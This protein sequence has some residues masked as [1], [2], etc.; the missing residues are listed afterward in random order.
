MFNLFS[1]KKSAPLVKAQHFGYMGKHPLR[2]DFVK[3][4]VDSREIISFDHW[5]QEGFASTSRM[6]QQRVEHVAQTSLF[7]ISGS[8][9]Q[10][11][12]IGVLQ[13]SE[14]SSKRKYPFSSYVICTNNEYQQHPA[15]LFFSQFNA[16]TTGLNIHQRI[17]ESESTEQ[18]AMRCAEYDTLRS[19]LSAEID[20]QVAMAQLSQVQMSEFWSAIGYSDIER[21]AQ[22][23]SQLAGVINT[24]ANRGCLRSQLGIKLPMPQF[25][26]QGRM[27]GSVWLHFITNMVADHN[28]QPW[29][30]YQLGDE[31]T[32]P[33]LVLFC[34]PVPAS[35]F[36][37]V[38]HSESRGD[39]IIDLTVWQPNLAIPPACV[40]FAGADNMNVF[41]ALRRWSKL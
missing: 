41:D 40:E 8:D 23:V 18:M 34:R 37:A 38:W 13:P 39:A 3:L 28:W 6:Q 4:N 35:Y 11:G 12:F 19:P 16:L 17:V 21:R 32:K 26:E 29:W 33:S 31:Q 30:F 14:D 2:P 36:D 1:K 5:L 27:V 7:F 15:F 22:L 20:Y 24:I 9:Q 10:S 25:S